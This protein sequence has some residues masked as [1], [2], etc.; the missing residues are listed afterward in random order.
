MTQGRGLAFV[1]PRLGFHF[2]ASTQRYLLLHLH[3]MYSKAS[4]WHFHGGPQLLSMAPKSYNMV[5]KVLV[6]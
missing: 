4:A 2:A 1:M 5:Y 6:A 3:G